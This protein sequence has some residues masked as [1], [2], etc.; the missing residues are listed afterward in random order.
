[1]RRSSARSQRADRMALRGHVDVDLR[2]RCASNQPNGQ[3]L[4]RVML[5]YDPPAGW[6]APRWEDSGEDRPSRFEEDLRRLNG[7]GTGE[8]ATT[9]DAGW[10]L[11]PVRTAGGRRRSRQALV[12]RYWLMKSEPT[13]FSFDPWCVPFLHEPLV[14][15]PQLSGR[16]YMRR[17]GSE[18]KSSFSTATATLRNC[19]IAEVAREGVSDLPSLIRRCA[20]RPRATRGKPI[21][22]C[23]PPG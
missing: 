17:C 21:G 1:M 18:T 5:Q 2:V 9:A 20:L 6:S 14:W 12:A 10:T 22:R 8:I 16:N 13:A 7:D 23:R 19:R 3:G 15:S 4:S 11:R